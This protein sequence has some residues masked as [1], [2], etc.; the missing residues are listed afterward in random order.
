M[1]SKVGGESCDEERLFMYLF[2]YA[3]CRDV[4]GSIHIHPLSVC[5]YVCIQGPA[6]LLTKDS[7]PI[8]GHRVIIAHDV[9]LNNY[10]SHPWIP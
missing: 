4:A 8:D 9:S 10:Q 5:M 6:H 1:R 3:W 7:K 2:M